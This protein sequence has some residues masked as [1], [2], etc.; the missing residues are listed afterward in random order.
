MKKSSLLLF[1]LVSHAFAQTTYEFNV[2]VPEPIESTTTVTQEEIIVDNKEEEEESDILLIQPSKPIISRWQLLI[3]SMNKDY[4]AIQVAIENGTDVNQVVIGSYNALHLAGMQDNLSLARLILSYKPNL[5]SLSKNNE[6]S[7]HWAAS[8]SEPLIIREE[9][10]IISSKDLVGLINKS[11]KDKRTALHF[12]ALYAGN[13]EVAKIL[14]DNKADI[15]AQDNSGRT[16]LQYAITARKWDLAELLLK[17]GADPSSKDENN[18]SAET[19]LIEKGD[20]EAYIKLYSYLS[21]DT[22]KFIEIQLNIPKFNLER[23]PKKTIV[24]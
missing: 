3:Q 19:S 10:A 13:L 24:T 15:N 2:P 16:A 20:I 8:S 4:T 22:Q 17:N 5:A 7:I 18:S 11:N 23:L 1:F 21:V 14:I 9:L 12:N 6:T